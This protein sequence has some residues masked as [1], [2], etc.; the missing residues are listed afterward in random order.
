MGEGRPIDSITG[1]C[2]DPSPCVLL[3]DV[4]NDSLSESSLDGGFLWF[5]YGFLFLF[6]FGCLFSSSSSSTFSSFSCPDGVIRDSIYFRRWLDRHP[7]RL[8]RRAQ[9]SG[10][11][12]NVS[13]NHRLTAG[14]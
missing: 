12:G 4:S 1:G 11:R 5:R 2:G 13:F 9:R 10:A 8:V 14:R 3:T 7:V 6:R